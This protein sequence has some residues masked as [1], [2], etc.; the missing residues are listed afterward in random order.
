MVAPV[1]REPKPHHKAAQNGSGEPSPLDGIT[2]E[3]VQLRVLIQNYLAARRDIIAAS[4][5]QTA[6]RI[7]LGVALG[8]PA[9]AMIVTASVLAITGLAEVIGVAFGGRMWAGN[10]IV[11]WTLVVLVVAGAFFLTSRWSRA[12]R[13]RTVERYEHEHSGT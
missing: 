10:L 4:L 3:L 12:A 2:R 1:T 5:R 9:L 11:G 6:T 8:I 7:V 13:Q